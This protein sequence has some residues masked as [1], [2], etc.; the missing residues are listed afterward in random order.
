MRRF[1]NM[2]QS[3]LKAA[4]KPGYHAV[5]LRASHQD[6][7]QLMRDR[8]YIVFLRKD[9]Y[10]VADAGFLAK[11]YKDLVTKQREVPPKK[12]S[13]LLPERMLEEVPAGG[14]QR[15]ICEVLGL[16]LSLKTPNPHAI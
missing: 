3:E 4:K 14:V 5:V 1:L 12:L 11:T 10:G 2:V 8:I 6:W 7:V 9:V 16:Q 13:D 15:S